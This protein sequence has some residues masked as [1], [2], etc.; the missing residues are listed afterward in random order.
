[1]PQH[2]KNSAAH[3]VLA[4][5]EILHRVLLFGDKASNASSACVCRAWFEPAIQASRLWEDVRLINAAQLLAPVSNS[6]NEHVSS[7]QI[8]I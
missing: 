5:L 8:H 3:R 7:L 6:G 1:M 2:W 4:I